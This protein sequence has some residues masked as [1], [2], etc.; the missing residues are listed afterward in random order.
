MGVW[1]MASVET[2]H[3]AARA[4]PNVVVIF[5]SMD[6]LLLSSF[7][8]TTVL[9]ELSPERSKSHAN[10]NCHKVKW[11]HNGACA[12]PICRFIFPVVMVCLLAAGCASTPENLQRET[13]RVIGDIS[14]DQVQVSNVKRGV[15][16][17]K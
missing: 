6:L 13:T 1:A 2:R 17:V 14:P 5:R 4:L 16:D 8:P 9:R 7:M 15:T 10:H 3:S 12:T 11:L